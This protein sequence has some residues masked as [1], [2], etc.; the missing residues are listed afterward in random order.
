VLAEIAYSDF[1]IGQKVCDLEQAARARIAYISRLGEA[2]VPSPNLVV[3]EGDV[4]NVIAA[5]K[6]IAGI[7]GVFASAEPGRGG[8]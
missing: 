2:V 5:E 4:L 7:A 1:W 6:E 3:Q 8:H